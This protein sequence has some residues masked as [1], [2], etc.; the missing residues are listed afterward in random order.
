MEEMIKTAGQTAMKSVE[1]VNNTSS[2]ELTNTLKVDKDDEG[3]LRIAS[4]NGEPPIHVDMEVLIW[5]FNAVFN[6]ARIT[7]VPY[8]TKGKAYFHIVADLDGVVEAKGTY[9]NDKAIAVVLDLLRG[10]GISPKD[11]FFRQ[12]HEVNDTD[13]FQLELLQRLRSDFKRLYR[14]TDTIRDGITHF[15]GSFQFYRGEVKFDIPL[16]DDVKQFIHEQLTINKRDY[17]NL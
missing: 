17:F 13:N 10:K 4:T 7:V 8:N 15:R 3:R 6:F 9:V 11:E 1:E 16:T 14:K 5:L 12:K 2:V